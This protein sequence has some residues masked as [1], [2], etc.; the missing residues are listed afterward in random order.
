MATLSRRVTDRLPI[1]AP[2]SA[3][4]ETSPVTR[5]ATPRQRR[6]AMQISIGLVLLTLALF[7][8]A[9]FHLPKFQA[10]FPIYQ[11]AVAG[12][13]LVTAFLMFGQYTATRS[14]ALLDLSAGSLYTA[15][16]LVTQ[17]LAFPGAF[18]EQGQLI[19][20]PQTLTWLWFFWHL[21]PAV[22]VILFA[23]MEH[24]QP[25]ARTIQHRK[26]ITKVALV[27]ALAFAATVALVTLCKN[28]LPIMDVSGDFSRITSS[29]IAPGLQ[30]LFLVALA[31]LWKASRFRNVLHLWLG[32]A[33][34]ALLCD[35]AITMMGA[36]RLSVGWYMGRVSALIS[37]SVM[38]FV[39]LHEV[40]HSYVRAASDVDRLASDNLGLSLRIDQAR[41]DTLTKLPSRE[42]F[43]ERANA[44]LASSRHTNT[45]FATLF[46]DLDGFKSI[47]DRF[48]HDHGD[49]ILIRVAEAIRTVLRDTD[50]AGRIGGDE[51]V[52]CLAAPADMSLAIANKIA[53]RIVE[54]IGKLGNGIGTSVGISTATANIDLALHEADEAMYESKK[55]GKN[56]FSLYRIKPT[57]AYSA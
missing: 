26:T 46:I 38:M 7:P 49:V 2:A 47:N 44:L 52:A 34:V 54:K 31:M 19:G 9:R 17:M 27:T 11:T 53:E 12:T 29:G 41:R 37:S 1:V 14:R 56:R 10:F 50:V 42:L 5:I 22:S 21:G 55:Q 15:A 24:R 25:G 57:L 20:G 32:L 8:F 18:L 35:N 28:A 6:M 16:I 43:M 45:G 30:V 40:K 48:G 23:S 13:Y 4:D 39:Y 3:N 33:M 36:S 51:F